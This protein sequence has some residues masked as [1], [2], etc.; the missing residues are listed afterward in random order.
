MSKTQKA[1]KVPDWEREM[2]FRQLALRFQRDYPGD[3]EALNKFVSWWFAER[4]AYALAAHVAA[5][6]ETWSP[7]GGLTRVEDYVHCGQ[8]S[9]GEVRYCDG[10]REIEELGR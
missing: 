5:C 3:I 2:D 8:E 10:A 6:Q 9:D 7:G 4:R 1:L